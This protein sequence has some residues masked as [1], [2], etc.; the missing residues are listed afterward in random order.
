MVSEGY[1]NIYS[2]TLEVSTPRSLKTFMNW[3]YMYQKSPAVSYGPAVNDR[4]GLLLM[5]LHFT[6]RWLEFQTDMPESL[7]D[8]EE[9]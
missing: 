1:V 9:T 2:T 6:M 3:V 4:D 7:R 8:F 5:F